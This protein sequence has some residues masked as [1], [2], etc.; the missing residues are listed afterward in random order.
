[1]DIHLS[2]RT[3]FVRRDNRRSFAL[4][5]QEPIWSDEQAA[6][7]RV[8]FR[9]MRQRPLVRRDNRERCALLGQERPWPG[10]N[11]SLVLATPTAT[12]SKAAAAA[13]HARVRC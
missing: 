9:L 2:W 5:G 3:T 4:L 1:M 12:A 8:G 11:A 10:G 13:Q 6:R 7:P